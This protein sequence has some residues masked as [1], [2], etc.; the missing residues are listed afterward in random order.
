MSKV[1][2]F[3]IGDFGRIAQLYLE[4]DS[5][6]DVVAFTAHGKYVDRDELNGL[7]IVP[8]EELGRQHPPDACRCWSP[9]A[10]RRSIGCARQST[11]GARATATS[12]SRT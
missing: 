9:S 3:G 7:P 1:V 6:H 10:S 4:R 5:E 2:I 8:F 11:K 12:S